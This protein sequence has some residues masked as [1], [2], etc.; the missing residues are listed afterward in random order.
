MSSSIVRSDDYHVELSGPIPVGP[1]PHLF[2]A[3][4]RATQDV[5]VVNGEALLCNGDTFENQ[6]PSHRKPLAGSTF[7]NPF[8]VTA[9]GRFTDAGQAALA[10][11]GRSVQTLAGRLKTCSDAV[12]ETSVAAC[13]ILSQPPVL[14]VDGSPVLPGNR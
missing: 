9:Q 11:E 3:S 8:G 2:L 1:V 10:V 6:G 4:P 13:V 5:L 14:F 7:M 12:A